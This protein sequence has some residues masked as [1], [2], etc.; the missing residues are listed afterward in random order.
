MEFCPFL[1]EVLLLYGARSPRPEALLVV[2]PSP[3]RSIPFSFLNLLPKAGPV[4]LSLLVY[5]GIR[6]YTLVLY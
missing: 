2:F 4:R 1:Y 3:L 5:L 6:G